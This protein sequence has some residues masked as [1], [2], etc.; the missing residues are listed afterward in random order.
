LVPTRIRAVGPG[1]S[2]SDGVF[3]GCPWKHV[4]EAD[5]ETDQQRRDPPAGDGA[6]SDGEREDD[7]RDG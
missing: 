4:S 1:D 2:E 3:A 6:D 5:K 7:E